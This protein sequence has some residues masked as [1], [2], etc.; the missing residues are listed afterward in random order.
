MAL[1]E[2]VRATVARDFDELF[3]RVEQLER[4]GGERSY[5][6]AGHLAERRQAVIALRASGLSITKIAQRLGIARTTVE[7]D[8]DAVPHE[9]PSYVVGVDGKTHPSANSSGRSPVAATKLGSGR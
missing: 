8:L 5:N 6:Y 4:Q 7:R 1:T 2:L 9:P 3:A